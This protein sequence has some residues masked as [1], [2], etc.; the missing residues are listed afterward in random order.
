MFGL[1]KKLREKD[2]EIEELKQEAFIKGNSAGE[3][4]RKVHEFDR[5]LTEAKNK[6]EEQNEAWQDKYSALYEKYLNLLERY[7]KVLETKPDAGKEIAERW[8]NDD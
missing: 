1:I 2:E 5:K 3:A 8:L 7:E 6:I 4:W